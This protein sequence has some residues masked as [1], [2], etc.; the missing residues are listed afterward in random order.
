MTHAVYDPEIE[1]TFTEVLRLLRGTE[2]PTAVVLRYTPAVEVNAGIEGETY[3]N[4]VEV[5]PLVRNIGDGKMVIAFR[6]KRSE[7][8]EASFAILNHGAGSYTPMSI[9]QLMDF[10]AKP[11]GPNHITAAEVARV[12]MTFAIL[13][14][15]FHRVVTS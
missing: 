3:M 14:D 10:F 2:F 4:Y 5:L 15:M 8:D 13:G 11:H 1:E 9:H 12:S 7:S 6:P